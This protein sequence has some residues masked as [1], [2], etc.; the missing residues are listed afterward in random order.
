MAYQTAEKHIRDNDPDAHEPVIVS[1]GPSHHH[2]LHLQA[3]IR[4]KWNCLRKFLG[5]NHGMTLE[6]YLKM[7][8]ENELD[9]RMAYSE[10]VGMSSDESVQMMLH[11]CSFVVATICFSK[12]K[13][14]GLETVQNPIRNEQTHGFLSRTFMDSKMKLKSDIENFDHFLRMIHSCISPRV[15]RDGGEPS[16]SLRHILN[17]MRTPFSNHSAEDKKGTEHQP[18]P[19]LEWIPNA[20]Q[21]LEAGVQFKRNEQATSF[22]DVTFRNGEMEI[23]LLEADDDTNTL[24]RNL[25]AFE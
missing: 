9:P 6:D 3:M 11:D 4:P 7:I 21:L 20:T 24:F 1:L 5:R 14:G 17:R 15:N 25:I 10:E 18:T 8:K 13:V 19:Q 23:P 16:T 12:E 22:L 2:K